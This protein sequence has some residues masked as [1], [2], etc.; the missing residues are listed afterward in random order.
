MY[1]LA[2][3]PSLIRMLERIQD[4]SNRDMQNHILERNVPF[5]LEKFVLLWVPCDR[6]HESDFST[7]CAFCTQR[8]TPVVMGGNGAQRSWRPV[9][10]FVYAQHGHEL[11]G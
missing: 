6:F 11:M 2:R 1:L 3:I 8:L 9:D 4:T 10:H 5:L 7:L